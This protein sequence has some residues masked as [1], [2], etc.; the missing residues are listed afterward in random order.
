MIARIG[1][2]GVIS[3]GVFTVTGRGGAGRRHTAIRRAWR[4]PYLLASIAKVTARTRLQQ[5]PSLSSRGLIYARGNVTVTAD[6]IGDA[7]PRTILENVALVGLVE[8]TLDLTKTERKRRDRSRYIVL[9][10]L[11]D[12]APLCVLLFADYRGWRFQR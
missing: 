10:Q 4:V 1:R 6:G 3:L 8:R 9:A 11:A 5:V 12:C 7:F 2:L